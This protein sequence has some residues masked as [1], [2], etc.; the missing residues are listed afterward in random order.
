VGEILAQITTKETPYT[1]VSFIDPLR[2]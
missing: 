1:D 2:F